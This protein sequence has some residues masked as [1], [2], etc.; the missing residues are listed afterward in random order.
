FDYRGTGATHADE[1]RE[2][3]K[4]WSTRLFA[5]DARHVLAACG[6]K[7]SHVYG[8][9][10]GGRVAQWLAIDH[11]DTV[12]HLV[13]ACTSPGGDKAVERSP[14]VRRQLGQRDPNGRLETLLDLFYTPAWRALGKRSSLLGDPKMSARARTGHLRASDHHDAAALLPEIAAPT[15]ILHGTDDHMAPVA[16]AHAIHGLIPGSRLSLTEGGRHGFFDEFSL[17]VTPDVLDFLP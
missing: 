1:T 15:L 4:D 16:N 5:A 8:A 10:M 13:L 14:E 12:D 17:R 2:A 7:S 6:A 9:S 11:P 3:T